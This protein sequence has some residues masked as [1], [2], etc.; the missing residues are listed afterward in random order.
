MHKSQ[1]IKILEQ[2]HKVKHRFMSDNEYIYLNQQTKLYVFEDG[3]N[4]SPTEF[5][6]Y[7]KGGS[8]EN[9]WDY[10]KK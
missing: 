10:Y 8:W 1:V 3:C 5:W 9:G 7:R 4:A 2:G 6:K